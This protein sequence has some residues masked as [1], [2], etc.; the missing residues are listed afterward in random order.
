MVDLLGMPCVELVVV[1][2]ALVL[3]HHIAISH[4]SFVLRHL[5]LE[6]LLQVLAGSRRRHLNLIDDLA[7]FWVLHRRISFVLMLF[8]SLKLLGKTLFLGHKVTFLA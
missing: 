2:H 6:H 1:E 3:A 4:A 5:S 7:E 8:Q